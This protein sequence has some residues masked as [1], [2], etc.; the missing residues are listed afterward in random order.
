MFHHRALLIIAVGGGALLACSAG[1]DAWA[2]GFGISRQ[3]ISNVGGSAGQQL[4]T[5]KQQSIGLG[6]TGSAINQLTLYNSRAQLPNVAYQSNLSSG[7]GI[8]SAPRLGKPFSAYSPSPT[9]SPYLNLFRNDLSGGSDLNYQTL[10]R[11]QLQQQ[12]FNSQAQRA[13]YEIARRVQAIAAQGDYNTA[14]SKE[15]YPTGHQTVFQYYG[16]HYPA[17]SQP[18]PRKRTQ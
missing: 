4:T 2:Q 14:G 3:P 12:Q 13:N 11:P 10:V 6:Y 7:S 18:R 15:L 16:R 1:D 9:V 17:F 8:N 5:L